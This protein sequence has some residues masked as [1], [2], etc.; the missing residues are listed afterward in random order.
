MFCVDLGPIAITKTKE[1]YLSNKVKRNKVK[2][3]NVRAP[4]ECRPV[5][6]TGPIFPCFL[7]LRCIAEGAGMMAFP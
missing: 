5:A 3:K 1:S 2:K 6:G 7:G 4:G